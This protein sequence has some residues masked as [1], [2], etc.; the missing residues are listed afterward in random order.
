MVLIIYVSL[1]LLSPKVLSLPFD[2]QDN[3]FLSWGPSYTAFHNHIIAGSAEHSISSSLKSGGF[4]HFNKRTFFNSVM[5]SNCQGP[6]SAGS[7]GYPQDER[8]WRERERE[9]ERRHV[10]P[11]LIGPSLRGRERERMTRR[12]CLQGLA[13]SGKSLFFTVAFIF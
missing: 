1:L 5:T 2:P 3:A 8:R 13:E 4:L 9:R 11:A 12:G 10:R 6:A 7:R